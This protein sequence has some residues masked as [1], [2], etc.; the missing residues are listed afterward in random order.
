MPPVPGTVVAPPFQHATPGIPH[1][2]TMAAPLATTVAAGGAAVA[3]PMAP[4]GGPPP[5][6]QEA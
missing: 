4:P 5:V 1:C 6:V 3:P 2:P